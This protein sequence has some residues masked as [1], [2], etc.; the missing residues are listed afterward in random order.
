MNEVFLDGPGETWLCGE[1]HN[2]SFLI[3]HHLLER[4]T[5][6]NFYEILRTELFTSNREMECEARK[7]LDAP[8]FQNVS[9]STWNVALH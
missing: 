8:P 2:Y 3:Q 9:K 4:S 1:L 7:A 5:I 6:I